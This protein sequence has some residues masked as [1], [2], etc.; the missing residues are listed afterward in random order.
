MEKEPQPSQEKILNPNE[1]TT[2]VDELLRES[3]QYDIDCLDLKDELVRTILTWFE[4]EKE[5]LEKNFEDR[6]PQTHPP[7]QELIERMR[8][9]LSLK[10]I[11]V[12]GAEPEFRRTKTLDHW[13]GEIYNKLLRELFNKKD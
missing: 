7:K 2:L 12:E 5:E 10:R 3:S 1:V 11:H 13:A 6:Y 9:V 8:S 4:K